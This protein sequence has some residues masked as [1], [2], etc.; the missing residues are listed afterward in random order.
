MRFLSPKDQATVVTSVWRIPT[1]TELA[2][3]ISQLPLTGHPIGHDKGSPKQDCSP[4]M[5]LGRHRI[6]KCFQYPAFTGVFGYK[7]PMALNVLLSIDGTAA[8]RAMPHHLTSD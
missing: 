5:L 2:S 6:D 8:M 7:I 1:K 4:V 3:F